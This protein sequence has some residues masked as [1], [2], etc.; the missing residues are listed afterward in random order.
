MTAGTT[1]TRA[2]NGG[3][4]SAESQKPGVCPAASTARKAANHGVIVAAEVFEAADVELGVSRAS[5]VHQVDL[6]RVT[7]PRQIRGDRPDSLSLDRVQAIAPV[8]GC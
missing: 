8:L 7:S 2:S 6:G 1:I 5:E 4:R 3:S